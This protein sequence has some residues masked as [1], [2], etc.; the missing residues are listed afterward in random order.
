MKYF[1]ENDNGKFFLNSETN[2]VYRTIG[3]Q[4]NPTLLFE[5]IKTGECESHAVNCMNIEKFKRMTVEGE[6]IQ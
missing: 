6:E 5:N 3:Y 2:E 1:T 4:P